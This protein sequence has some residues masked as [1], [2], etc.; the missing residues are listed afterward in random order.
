LS[1]YK[2][3]QWRTALYLYQDPDKSLLC[4]Y[5]EYSGDEYPTD[6]TNSIARIHVRAKDD[7]LST[8]LLEFS[9]VQGNIEIT[10]PLELS[11]NALLGATQL[12]I[13]PAPCPWPALRPLR[14][15][16][17]VV[18]PSQRLEPEQTLL[19]IK[20][21]TAPLSSSTRAPVGR[22]ALELTAV[23]TAALTFDQ[24]WFDLEVTLPSGDEL[25][26]PKG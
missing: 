25:Y 3:R 14:F 17:L 13:Q 20:P 2:S 19:K 12:N 22:I 8:R 18:V 10:P 5:P 4:G 16:G 21:L 15:G 23:E 9:P 6:L 24:G 26:T 11:A 7:P 1:I